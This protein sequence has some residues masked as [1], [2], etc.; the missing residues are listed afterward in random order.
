M[1]SVMGRIFLNGIV[2][3]MDFSLEAVDVK[4]VGS[5]SNVALLK[6][7]SF[8][9]SIDL[10]DHHIMPNVKFTFF[11]EKGAVYVELDDEGFFTSVIVF[12]LRFYYRI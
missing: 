12:F 3:Q 6:P 11:V 4:L 5:C 10:A 1:L 7:I 8:H 2:G 9:H